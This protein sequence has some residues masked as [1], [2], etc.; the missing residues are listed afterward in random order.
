MS[1]QDTV[2]SSLIALLKTGAT[3]TFSLAVFIYCILRD[4]ASLLLAVI[5]FS[6]FVPSQIIV[7]ACAAFLLGHV[8][9]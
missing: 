1:V 8:A 9:I 4:V 3:F 5:A 2:H 7:V 6:E